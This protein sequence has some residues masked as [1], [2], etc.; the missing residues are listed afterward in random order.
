MLYRA[1]LVVPGQEPE[2]STGL[3][4]PLMDG[5]RNLLGVAHVRAAASS[6]VRSGVRPGTEVQL[7]LVGTDPASNWGD[8]NLAFVST[9]GD[10]ESGGISLSP[11]MLDS[12]GGNPSFPAGTQVLSTSTR[13]QVGEY[14]VLGAAGLEPIYLVLQAELVD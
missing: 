5:M 13:I 10:M 2:G 11:I 6:L 8:F 14:T 12:E 1:W 3:P 9:A 4:A 7:K